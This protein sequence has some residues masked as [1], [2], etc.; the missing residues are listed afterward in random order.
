MSL[1]LSTCILF[2]L[3]MQSVNG[4]QF[5]NIT[6]LPVLFAAVAAAAV[7]GTVIVSLTCMYFSLQ[8]HALYFDT[9]VLMLFDYWYYTFPRLFQPNFLP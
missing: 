7:F 9:E 5:S 2:I 8:A 4:A 6:F 3:H 1:A